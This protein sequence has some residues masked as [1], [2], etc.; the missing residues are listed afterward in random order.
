MK[1]KTIHIKRY[2]SILDLKLCI[3]TSN[4]F[5]SICGENNTGKTNIL[6]ALNLFFNPQFYVA[7]DDSPHHKYEGT[8]GAKVF[9]E[10]AIEFELQDGDKY[11]IMKKF[12]LTTIDKTEGIKLKVAQKRLKSEKMT[13]IEIKNFL[14]KIA[15]FYLESVNKS[16][17]ILI[18]NLLEDIYDVEY[19]KSRFSGLKSN[20]KNSF[21]EYTNGLLDLL[22]GL[23]KEINPI[24]EDYNPNWSVK[25]RFPSNVKRFRDLISDD[26]EFYIDDK[27][28]I[29]ISGKG[30]G[31]QRLAYILLHTRIIDKI[32]NKKV[33]LLIDEPDVY[34]HQGLQKNL[35]HQ[36]QLLSKKSQIFITTHSPIF[37]DS[38]TLDNVFLLDLKISEEKHFKRIS[39]NFNILETIKVDLDEIL[40]AKKI[41]SYLGISDYDYDLLDK[42]NIMVEGDSD[43]RYITELAKYFRLHVPNIISMNGVGNCEKYLE[44]YNSFYKNKNDNP[45]ILILFDNDNAGRETY[46]KIIS[47]IEKYR[48]QELKLSV[49]LN[50]NFLGEKPSSDDIK[51]QKIFSDHQIEDFIYPKI[52]CH[53]VN[54]ILRKRNLTT[55]NAMTVIEKI[56]KPAYKE[57]GIL[58]LIENE[59]NELNP[60]DGQ[61]IN[62]ISSSGVTEQIKNGI[63]KL[64]V[65]EGDRAISRLIEEENI[66]YPYVKQYLEKITN[67]KN[68]IKES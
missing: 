15:F 10:I 25:F 1:I 8:R 50:P 46:K 7:K 36:I 31:L 48:Y 56:M 19:E 34:L 18:N 49:D 62:F 43:L 40:G 6:R 54:I 12:N 52:M 16:I 57:R 51:S 37:I 14:N 9:P 38:Y 39:K 53:L 27:S 47:H 61:N 65:I 30:A 60:N 59:K 13:D 5:I 11:R 35:L 28:N 26:L 32:K 58:N 68:Y 21:E 17:P 3:T 42:Y 44:F 41:K 24:F 23:A 45:F 55:I 63:S 29:N 64:F 66:I 67:Y 33:I 2:R 20:L 4:N 22:N